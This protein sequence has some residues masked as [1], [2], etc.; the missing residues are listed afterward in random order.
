MARRHDDDERGAENHP[1]GFAKLAHAIDRTASLASAGCDALSKCTYGL[2]RSVARNDETGVV[3][4]YRSLHSVA[5]VELH[6]DATDMRLHCGL[7]DK[8]CVAD[9][10]VRQAAGQSV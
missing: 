10:S 8:H 4:R 3:G 1:T 9:L 7:G 2:F 6:E 5:G